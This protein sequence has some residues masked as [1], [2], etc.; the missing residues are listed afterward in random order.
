[1]SRRSNDGVRQRY[2]GCRSL[3]PCALP[4]VSELRMARA[5]SLARFVLFDE[6]LC[7]CPAQPAISRCNNTRC[8]HQREYI[9]TY[10]WP[11]SEP[12][13]HTLSRTTVSRAK[14]RRRVESGSS[15]VI[16]WLVASLAHSLARPLPHKHT[17]L[18][19]A[20]PSTGSGFLRLIVVSITSGSVCAHG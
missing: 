10:T 9:L 1:M 2:H 20:F 6:C 12:F 13:T 8:H 7:L 4:V 15:G 11:A 3:E 5:N 17:R 18:P 16:R 14:G 19:A